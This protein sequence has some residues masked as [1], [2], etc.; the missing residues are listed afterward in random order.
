MALDLK[1]VCVCISEGRQQINE[2]KAW[3][4]DSFI[5]TYRSHRCSSPSSFL[6][7]S[8]GCVE[9]APEWTSSWRMNDMGAAESQGRKVMGGAGRFRTGGDDGWKQQWRSSHQLV[10]IFPLQHTGVVNTTGITGTDTRLSSIVRFQA[11]C[12]CTCYC[13]GCDWELSVRC[14]WMS[15]SF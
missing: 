4:E 10:L 15:S 7:T 12:A 8:L 2:M 6:S 5:N 14:D 1:S 11:T 13:S 9:V 3:M